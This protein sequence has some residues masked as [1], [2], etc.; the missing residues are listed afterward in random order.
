M[1]TE[2][3]TWGYRRIAGEIAEL[4]R[5]IAPATVWAISKKAGF[6]PAPAVT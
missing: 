5:K 3:P 4:G 1:A 6:D 2:N